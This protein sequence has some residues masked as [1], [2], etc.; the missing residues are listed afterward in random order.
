MPRGQGCWYLGQRMLAQS[1]PLP[2][3]VD[4]KQSPVDVL[5]TRKTI[6]GEAPIEQGF[7]VCE[8]AEMEPSCG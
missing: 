6:F 5:S 3:P 7:W 2:A 1:L 4:L 8:E